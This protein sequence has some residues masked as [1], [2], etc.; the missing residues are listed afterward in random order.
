M[1]GSS[2]SSLRKG[3]RCP[4]VIPQ[5]KLTFPPSVRFTVAIPPDD[6]DTVLENSFFMGEGSS[7]VPKAGGEW[8]LGKGSSRRQISTVIRTVDR[9]RVST[10]GYGRAHRAKMSGVNNHGKKVR[11]ER[12]EG[13]EERERERGEGGGRIDLKGLRWTLR[14]TWENWRRRGDLT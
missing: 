12:F 10:T 7:V 13:V 1:R 5:G 9:F 2:S 11:V 4:F 14:S 3:C 8:T 6:E